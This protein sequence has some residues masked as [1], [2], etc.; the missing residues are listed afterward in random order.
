MFQR[1]KRIVK[2]LIP[3]RKYTSENFTQYDNT[4][5]SPNDFKKIF[6]GIYPC[7]II[8]AQNLSKS[9]LVD[10]HGLN[11][12]LLG[13]F[14]KP[15]Y[16]GDVEHIARQMFL[17]EDL[18]PH[19]KIAVL[20]LDSINDTIHI[21]DVRKGFAINPTQN[22][23][24]YIK[25]T[26]TIRQFL[27][28]LAQNDVPVLKRFIW[29]NDGEPV[30][31]YIKNPSYDLCKYAVSFNS[32]ELQYVKSQTEE[33]CNI[34][35]SRC[36]YALEHARIQTE[37][38]CTRAV[39]VNPH[40]LEYV[41]TQTEAICKTAVILDGMMLKHVKVQTDE[42]CRYAIS[43]A[44]PAM[45]YVENQTESICKYAIDRHGGNA[46]C[47]I[48]NKTYDMCKY[49]VENNGTAIKYVP[50]K[51]LELCEIA[52]RNSEFAHKYIDQD[53]LSKCKV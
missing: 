36:P 10:G 43:N 15:T 41:K 6:K 35:V 7:K 11:G 34:A 25:K 20:D 53:M 31:K 39:A 12:S 3:I 42:I 1:F 4:I 37:E 51:T 27:N 17:T 50:N 5:L 47:N 52:L 21:I 13:D 33:L 48:K 18:K 32:D 9:Y 2:T 49:A 24:K 44:G 14:V 26:Y 38:M 16:F 22:T 45:E 23:D 46:L 8:G 29:N 40:T 30:L 28:H 19:C